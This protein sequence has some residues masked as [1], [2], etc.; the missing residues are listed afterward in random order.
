MFKFEK[1]KSCL[2][3]VDLFEIEVDIPYLK[4]PPSEIES[5][6]LPDVSDLFYETS[7]A[8]LGLYY[9]EE[10]IGG[11]CEFDCPFVKSEYPDFTGSDALELF[12]STRDARKASSVTSFCH[13]FVIF[14]VQIGQ[15]YA[16][17]ITHFRHDDSRALIEPSPIEV[18]S[19]F[20]KKRYKMSFFIPKSALHGFEGMTAGF[21]FTY[22]VHSDSKIQ[23]FSVSS[24]NFNVAAMPSLWAY[25][26]I[27]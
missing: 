27:T 3:P 14:P 21:S 2:M 4:E 1:D 5:I 9:N 24:E 11:I 26:K 20:E 10:G 8:T 6:A 22:I 12:I 25:G 17:E 13:H 16:K 19:F 7:F 23:H 15:F 18:S